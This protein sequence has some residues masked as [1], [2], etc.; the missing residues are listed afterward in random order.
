MGR[1]VTSRAPHQRAD[2]VDTRDQ[3]PEAEYRHE[4]RWLRKR[5]AAPAEAVHLIYR[6]ESVAATARRVIGGLVA[7]DLHL[8]AQF[9]GFANRFRSRSHAK[10]AVDAL[11]MRLDSIH[12]DVEVLGDLS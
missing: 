9:A 6:R 1:L 10:F 5:I 8:E 3:V 11:E 12:R 2:S 4:N 7:G